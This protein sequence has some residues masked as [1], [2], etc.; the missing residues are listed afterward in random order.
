MS[1]VRLAHNVSF[2]AADCDGVSKAIVLDPASLGT[3]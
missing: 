2:A 3:A 1:K